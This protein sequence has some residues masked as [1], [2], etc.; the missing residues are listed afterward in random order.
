MHLSM[1]IV[2]SL[3]VGLILCPL[4]RVRGA[5]PLL[6]LLGPIPVPGIDGFHLLEPQVQP[7][8]GYSFICAT[9]VPVGTSVRIIGNIL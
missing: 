8:S 5:G 3:G 9:A 1:N 4:G 7:K 2:K 6:G